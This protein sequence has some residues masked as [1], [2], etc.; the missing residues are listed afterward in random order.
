MVF[1]PFPASDT[2]PFARRTHGFYTSPK[3]EAT[4]FAGLEPRILPIEDFT[5]HPSPSLRYL[6]SRTDTESFGSFLLRGE[7]E[8]SYTVVFCRSP[9]DLSLAG[10]RAVFSDGLVT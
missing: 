3:G 9:I 1:T 2:S 7:T 6:F 8:G 10:S 5:T 4:H